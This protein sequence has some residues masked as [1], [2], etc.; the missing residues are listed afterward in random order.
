LASAR[1][2][3]SQCVWTASMSEMTGTRLCEVMTVPFSFWLNRRYAAF[4][5]SAS[6]RSATKVVYLR[7]Q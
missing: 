1:N 7:V 6:T 3:P 4:L 5:D 2:L